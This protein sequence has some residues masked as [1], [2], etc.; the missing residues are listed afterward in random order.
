MNKARSFIPLL[1][2]LISA[3]G[4]KSK[5]AEEQGEKKNY[6]PVNEFILGEMREIDSMPV[7]ILRKYES[8]NKKD[9]GYIQ[10][11]EFK[12][13]AQ[14]FI[15]PELQGEKFTQNFN[16]STIGDETTGYYT[17]SYQANNDTVHVMRVDVNAIPGTSSDKVKSIYIEKKY[18][19]KD[20]SVIEKLYWKSTKSFSIWKEKRAGH[21]SARTEKLE[22]IWDPA[23]YQ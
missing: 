18:S 2:L 12:A 6:F 4:D 16:E 1:I 7:G 5:P 23:S 14:A 17:F 20:T 9:S 10:L 21:D 22:V 11:P 19:N 15:N 3:C 8:G 13:L